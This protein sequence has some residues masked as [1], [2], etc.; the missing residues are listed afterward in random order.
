MNEPVKVLEIKGKDI[1]GKGTFLFSERAKQFGK[2]DKDGNEGDGLNAIY[3]GLLQ[4]KT[5]S[6]VDFWECCAAVD[7]TI[8]RKHVEE[9]IFAVIE[10]NED[11]IELLQGAIDIL[12]NSGFF[13]RDTKTFWLNVNQSY[14]AAKPEEGQTIQEARE[15]AKEHSKMLKIMHQAIVTGEEPEEETA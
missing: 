15:A 5:E 6:I 10:E 4:S 1:E 3:T 13:K 12:D 8:Q 14:R 7:K 9:A 11:T 2:K